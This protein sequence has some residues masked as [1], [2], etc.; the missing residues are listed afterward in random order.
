M[1]N[2]WVALWSCLISWKITYTAR[3]ESQDREGKAK[4]LGKAKAWKIKRGETTSKVERISL[5]AK[6][7]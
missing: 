7:D 2:L 5:E 6:V 3:G 4:I 1:L